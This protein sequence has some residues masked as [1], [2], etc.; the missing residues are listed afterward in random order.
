MSTVQSVSCEPL[1]KK[2]G[3]TLKVGVDFTLYGL[4]SGE[5]LTGTPTLS[6]S[7]GITVAS[8]AVNTGTFTNRKKGTVAIG[9]GVQFTLSGGTAGTDYY[10]DVSCGTTNSQTLVVRCPVE[11]RDD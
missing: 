11:V 6:A 1:R 2:P 4:A 3:E 10:V 8:P 5:T 9:K 7:S